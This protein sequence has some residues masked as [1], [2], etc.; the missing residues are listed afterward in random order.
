MH[1]SMVR[2]ILKRMHYSSANS[3]VYG[4]CAVPLAVVIYIWD[5]YSY[6]IIIFT[7]YSYPQPSKDLHKP[8]EKRKNPSALEKPEKKK[9]K[10]I[11]ASLSKKSIKEVK[12]GYWLADD[13]IKVAS[14]MLKNQFPKLAGLFSTVLGQNLSFPVCKEPFIQV[15]HVG[16]DHWVTVAS[17]SSNLVHLYD[18]LYD[19]VHIDTKMQIAAMM[20]T[21]DPHI[22]VL[23]HKIQFQRG[24]SDC[25]LYSIAYATDVAHGNDPA[26]FKYKQELLRSH[27]LTS[28]EKNE[29]IPFPSEV[30]CRKKPKKICISIMC[31]C[32]LPDNGK[33][34]MAQCR[35]CREW[36]HK[37]C[38]GIPKE[39]FHHHDAVWKCSVCFADKSA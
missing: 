28:L 6:V 21:N 38:E 29:L 7:C 36:F 16:D 24:S 12:K 33:E 32:R 8:G 19:V 23:V 35:N 20:H 37:S 39:V 1:A 11:T 18:S 4:I 25:G 5:S 14:G 17:V 9:K 30:I 10:K 31:T 27:F 3:N 22:N 2:S 26:S 34:K 13:H 15:L